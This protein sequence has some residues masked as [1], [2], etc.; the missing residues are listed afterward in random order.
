VHRQYFIIIFFE[1]QVCTILDKG[2]YLKGLVKQHLTERYLVNWQVG[3][4]VWHLHWHH[5]E[6]SVENVKQIKGRYHL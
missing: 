4:M 5:D 6:L 3:Q 1:K 2:A